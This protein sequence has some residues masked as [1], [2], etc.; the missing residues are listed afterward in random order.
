MKRIYKKGFT[1]IEL[2]AVIIIIGL[3]LVIAIPGITKYITTSRNKTYLRTLD[4]YAD[5]LSKMIANNELPGMYEEDTTYYIPFN[6]IPIEKGGKSPNGDWEFAYVLTTNQNNQR[7]YYF[8][9]KDEKS[10]GVEGISADKIKLSDV[11]STDITID[12]PIAISGTKKMSIVP[13]SCDYNATTIREVAFKPDD[14]CFEISAEGEIT[15]WNVLGKYDVDGYIPEPNDPCYATN[16]VIPNMIKGITV[17]K[18][19]TNISEI[20]DDITK[21]VFAFKEL[22]SIVLPDT[23]TS[24]SDHAFDTCNLV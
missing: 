24:S 8:Y 13:D 1:L 3:L 17:K 18:I 9:T 6:C 11:K 21:L 15:K 5:G 7:K 16:L 19:S 10:I 23:V 22:K 2:L 12:E 4:S 20:E 14:A